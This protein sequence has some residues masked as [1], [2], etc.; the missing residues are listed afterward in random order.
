MSDMPRHTVRVTIDLTMHSEEC[1]T[2]HPSYFGRVIEA[3]L[4][5]VAK[6]HGGIATWSVV[7]TETTSIVPAVAS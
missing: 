5:K 2:W 1:D 6:T 7:E 3:G 4:E